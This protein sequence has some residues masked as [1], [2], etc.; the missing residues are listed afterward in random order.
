MARNIDDP[1]PPGMDPQLRASLQ[2]ALN[3]VFGGNPA[4][5]DAWLQ[6]PEPRLEGRTPIAVLEAGEFN[7]VMRTL[8]GHESRIIQR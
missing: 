6:A 3:K 2:F 8:A 7:R 5:I 1:L 4:R